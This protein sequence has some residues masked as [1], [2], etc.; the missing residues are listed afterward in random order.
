MT[1]PLFTGSEWT[2]ELLNRAMIECGIIA[3]DELKLDTYPNSIEIVSSE[4][5]LDAY[6][7]TGLPIIYKHWSFGKR[8]SRELD[9]YKA[10]KNGLA[11]EMV[12]NLCPCV[13]FLMEENTACTQVLVIAH[14]AYGHNSVFKNNYLFKQWTDA[15]GMLDYLIFA[16]NYIASCEERYGEEAVELTLNAAHALT[17]NG[18]DRYKRPKKL[19]IVE[20]KAKQKERVEYTEGH[21]NELWS[22]LIKP[23]E[24]KAKLIVD[25]KFPKQPEENI[26]YFLEKNS[27]IL[28]I[29]QREVLRI[30]R[31]ISQYFRPQGECVTGNHLISTPNGL[32]RLD[33]LIDKNGY[34]PI[35]NTMLL[36]ENNIYTNISHTYKHKTDVIRLTTTTGKR[37]TCTP[38]HPLKVFRNGIEIMC[39][40]GDI[41]ENDYIVT[42]L[43]YDIFSKTNKK[44][45]KIINDEKL[46]CNICGLQ[47]NFLASHVAQIHNLSPAD[48]TR[49]FDSPVSNN[50]SRINK[51]KNIINKSPSHMN[52][53]LAEVLAYL[54]CCNKTNIQ[55]SVI[56]FSNKDFNKVNKFKILLNRL[57]E[58]KVEITLN[59][60][61]N[62]QITFS[63]YTLK[64][65][66]TENFPDILTNN[67]CVPR[68][69]RESARPCVSSYIKTLIDLISTRR[70]SVSHFHVTTYVSNYEFLEHLQTLLYGFGI[71]SKI[72]NNQFTTFAG[73]IEL[74]QLE[75]LNNHKATAITSTL[76]IIP[77]HQELFNKLIGSDLIELETIS[78]V[79]SDHIIPGAMDLLKTIRSTLILQR[80]NYAKTNAKN[81][82]LS[83]KIKVD[84]NLLVKNHFMATTQLPEI[85]ANELRVAHVQKYKEK[86][87][88]LKKVTTIPEAMTL[89]NLIENTKNKFFDKVSIIENDIGVETVYDVTVPYNHLFWLDGTISHN[90]KTLNEGWASFTHY[91]IMNRLYD[92][93]LLTDG[94]ML[95]FIKMHTGVVHQPNYNDP[96]Y[97]G[98][99]PYYM[100]F[101]MFSDIKRICENPTK[102]DIDFFPN[103]VNQPWVDVCLDVVANYRDES[104]VRQF[105]SPTLVRKIGLFNLLDD[106]KEA[107]YMITAIQDRDGFKQIR[108]ALAN[109]YEP[110]K[111]SP[112]IE[113]TNVDIKGD[114]ALTLTYFKERNRDIAKSWKPT[115]ASI[116]YLWGHTVKLIDNF[117]NEIGEV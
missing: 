83:Y 44:L 26:L 114:R 58:I 36:T 73:L 43:N 67:L 28:E 31:K 107:D 82:N 84:K 46:V 69:I 95:E 30:V 108:T 101:E 115:L 71:V 4:Q 18:I 55:N 5:M 63:S 70:T 109:N 98:L 12:L 65:F 88:N 23:K 80:K 106:K 81:R 49:K 102:E 86:F 60:F 13:N 17:E 8:F 97:D 66:I 2:F 21:V 96:W 27:P 6:S 77:D 100:G 99:N 87:E 47:S 72:T 9:A 11:Y 34:N 90:T 105:L 39:K 79:L 19:S 110:H 3:K 111:W 74:A 32:L 40:A 52:S 93:G 22:T 76:T 94:A 104:M 25:E 78:D 24:K 113:I 89:Y 85:R 20:E 35:N 16:K 7:S 53:D 54:Q 112:K 68:I 41:T 59:E 37:F 116:K 38:E 57:F 62:H 45:K 75:P 48:Y 42:N 92:K 10:G 61:F 64:L 117:G 51:S 56:C 14:A 91:Y 15:E 33:E 50:L 1:K 29:W 103:I